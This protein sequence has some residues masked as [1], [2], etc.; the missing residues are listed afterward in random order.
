MWTGG[1]RRLRGHLSFQ[2]LIVIKDGVVDSVILLVMGSLVPAEG[3][4]GSSIE[5]HCPIFACPALGFILFFV[6][7]F[8]VIIQEGLSLP[9]CFYPVYGSLSIVANGNRNGVV[10]NL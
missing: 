8:I 1:F 5:T 7:Y 10:E 4:V 6:V 2:N 3:G 9:Y